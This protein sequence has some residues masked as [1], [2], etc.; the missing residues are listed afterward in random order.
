MTLADEDVLRILRRIQGVMHADF[1]RSEDREA[2]RQRATPVSAENRGV[3]EVLKRQHVV[4]LFK[5]ASFRPPPEPTLFLVDAKGTVLGREVVPPGTSLEPRE[6]RFAFLGKDFILFRG[7][8]PSG[9]LRFL[10][11]P[12]RFP[13]LE[14]LPGLER[15][16]SA[17]PDP[18]QDEYLK[19]RFGIPQG[20]RLASVLV[21]YDRRNP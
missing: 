6:R 16:V 8:K 7:M 14:G 18:P 21:G 3:E 1:L 13:E 2:L 5:D 4:C 20:N 12:V 15:V 10:L 17:S 11:P 19:D 9:P